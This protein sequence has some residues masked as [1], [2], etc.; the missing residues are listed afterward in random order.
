MN[1]SEW[2]GTTRS[3]WSAV[4]RSMLG[5]CTASGGTLMLC[6]GEYLAGDEEETEG[7]HEVKWRLLPD[8]RGLCLLLTS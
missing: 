5:Y 4:S 3:S 1:L 7:Q 6:S 2:Q 8:V